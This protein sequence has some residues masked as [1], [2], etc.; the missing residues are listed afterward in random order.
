LFNIQTQ[1]VYTIHTCTNGAVSR[2][3]KLVPHRD[4]YAECAEDEYCYEVDKLWGEATVEAVVQPRHKRAH[5]QQ[6]DT[7]V[8]KSTQAIRQQ[9][10]T[11]ITNIF[12][13]ISRQ[14]SE[15]VQQLF[16]LPYLQ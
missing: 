8:V 11:N 10:I 15:I 3:S 7:T 2:F 1:S 13:L 4:D 16:F 12:T 5:C 9:C 6:C 14:L